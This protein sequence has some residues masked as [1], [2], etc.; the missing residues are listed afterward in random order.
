MINDNDYLDVSFD[1]DFVE[2]SLQYFEVIDKFVVVFGFP[3]DLRNG[4]FAWVNGIDDLTI[5][6]P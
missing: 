2:R 5:H 1:S 4:Y 3:V 6:S